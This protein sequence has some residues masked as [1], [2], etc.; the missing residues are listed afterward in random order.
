LHEIFCK[1]NAKHIT[2]LDTIAVMETHEENEKLGWPEPPG[3]TLI[4]GMWRRIS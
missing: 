1:V 3:D 4:A 2:F